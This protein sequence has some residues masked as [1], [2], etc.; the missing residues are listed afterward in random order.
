M[1]PP[2]MVNVSRFVHRCITAQLACH[3]AASVVC[4]RIVVG[5]LVK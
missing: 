1:M 2:G 4:T 5:V 3:H